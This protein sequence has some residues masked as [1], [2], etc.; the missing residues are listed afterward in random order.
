MARHLARRSPRAKRKLLCVSPRTVATSFR[1]QPADSFA[2]CS[3]TF[4]I[5][6]TETS[7]WPLPTKGDMVEPG[8]GPCFP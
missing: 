5:S 3:A 6:D 2:P 7:V 8:G 4:L 1:R